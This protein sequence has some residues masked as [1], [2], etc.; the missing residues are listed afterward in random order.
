[1]TKTTPR[2][3]DG[4]R[5]RP[6]QAPGCHVC[7]LVSKAGDQSPPQLPPKPQL[8]VYLS[9]QWL[10]MRCEVRPLGLFLTRTLWYHVSNSSWRGWYQYY[11]DPNCMQ[12]WFL[13]RVE[14][15]FSR[16]GP[17]LRLRGATN[18]DFQ[19]LTAEVTPQDRGIVNNLNSASEDGRCGGPW[20]LNRPQDVTLAGGCYLLGLSV[21]STKYEV[22]KMEVDMYGN[23]LLFLGD[24]DTD[25]G[26]TL[27]ERR[28]TAYQTPLIQCR[29]FPELVTDNEVYSLPRAQLV[30]MADAGAPRC[31]PWKAP[32]V[33]LVP[34]MLIRATRA[35]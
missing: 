24:V 30:S 6:V 11:R 4:P 29:V 13:L 28:A 25:G 9:G 2:N 8:P 15:I 3:S 21:P 14:G 12:P 17:S 20:F 32:L 16:A 34:L 1:M 31:R 18:Y 7:H 19:L 26:V 27:P 22:V 23:A 5:F 35:Y 10:S 33:T